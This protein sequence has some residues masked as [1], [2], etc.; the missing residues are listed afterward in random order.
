MSQQTKS[1]EEELTQ[2]EELFWCGG[3]DIYRR[4]MHPDAVMRFPEP[5]GKLQSGEILESIEGA[6]RWANV[7]MLDVTVREDGDNLV[8]DYRA[9]GWRPGDKSYDAQCT[10]TYVRDDEG[11]L[12]LT[13]HEQTPVDLAA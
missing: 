11:E 5:V 3:T 6:H 2:I 10:S 12:K 9:H 8:L 1:L 13:Y 4:H 7:E